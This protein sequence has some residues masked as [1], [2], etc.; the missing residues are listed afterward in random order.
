MDSIGF[1]LSD[2][3]EREKRLS[4]R[5]DADERKMLEVLAARGGL[6]V[7]DVVR[8]FARRAYA[9]TIASKTKATKR[10]G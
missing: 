5:I 3:P 9:E 2:M 4:I 6:T 7:S 1:M 8:L 10:I